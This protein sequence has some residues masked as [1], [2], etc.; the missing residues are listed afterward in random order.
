MTRAGST[1]GLFD[2]TIL[3]P[4]VAAG[5]DRTFAELTNRPAWAADGWRR[6][7]AIWIDEDSCRARL[8]R[9]SAVDLGGIGKGFSAARALEAMRLAWP[10]MTGGFADLG[11]D[12]AFSGR[13]LDA[14]A[15]RVAVAD[16]RSPGAFLATLQLNGGGVATSGRDRRRFGPGR[17]LHHLIDPETG[18]PAV[19]GPLAVTVVARDPSEA[20]ALGTAFAI[21]ELDDVR[22]LA[23]ERG[24]A[25]LYVPAAGSPVEVG[26]AAARAALPNRDRGM[27][28][29]AAAVPVAWIVARAAGLVAFG[30]LTLSVWLG[31]AMSTRILGP[32]R[33]KSLF[34]W[35][36]TLAW[37]GLSM[38]GLHVGAVLLDPVLH[39][40]LASVLVPFAATW[41]PAAIAAGVV[42]GWLS[43][44]L[45]VSFRLRKWIGQR[46]WR[47]LHYASFAAFGLAL[48]HALTAGTDLVG[49][50]GP[51][52]AAIALGPVLWLGF[53]RI[54]LPRAARPR[55]RPALAEQ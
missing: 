27:T 54:L 35:H 50:R 45:A 2:P 11:G 7:A 1:A 17:S 40:G 32:R 25:A 23:R 21:S 55:P 4:L 41:R 5:Y 20:E 48:A 49:I 44:M 47:R 38:L 16:P 46:G 28:G 8:E 43:L 33:Q 10:E 15:W 6:G 18:A 3:Q 19:R 42:A 52:L 14:A 37:T 26:S 31:L 36:R 29:A 12:L 51:I 39:F 34:G 9:G 22:R 53:A 30:L 24:V 13:P